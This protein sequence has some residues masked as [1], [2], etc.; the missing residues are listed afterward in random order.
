MTLHNKL[1]VGRNGSALPVSRKR[2]ITTPKW[3]KL[4]ARGM[5][6]KRLNGMDAICCTPRRPTC[7]R[8]R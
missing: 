4:R 7:T 6:M 3:F 1:A 8:T 5:D 2:R